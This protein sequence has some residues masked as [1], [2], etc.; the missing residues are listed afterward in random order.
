MPATAN[1]KEALQLLD[2][3][4]KDLPPLPTGQAQHCDDRANPVKPT[5]GTDTLNDL[6]GKLPLVSNL[7]N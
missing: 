2:V 4:E 6:L 7:N 5:K 3:N 1:A